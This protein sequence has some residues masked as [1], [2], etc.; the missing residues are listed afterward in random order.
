MIRR[1]CVPV[2]YILATIA[3]AACG[4]GGGGGGGSGGGTTSPPPTGNTI[5]YGSSNYQYT[6]GIEAQTL[7][8]SN[9]S[10]IKTWS[11]S[12]ALPAGLTFDTSTGA[13]SGTPTATSP[14]TAYA[15]TGVS[16]GGQVQLSLAIGVTSN[17]LLNLGDVDSLQFIQFDAAHAVTQDSSGHWILWNY[18]TTAQIANGVSLVSY[19][20]PHTHDTIETIPAPV[21]LAGPTAVIQTAN[22]LEVRSS[23]TGEV[24]AEIAVHL[25]WW[26]LAADGSYVCAGNGTSLTCWSPSG[27]QLFSEAGNYFNAMVFAAPSQLLVGLGGAGPQVIET[28]STATW[29]SSVGPAFQG[30]FSSWFV[31]GSHFLATIPEGTQ[32]GTTIAAFNTLYVYSPASV[33][34]DAATMP[35][36]Q[37]LTGQGNWFWTTAPS[38]LTLY[39]I[40]NNTTSCIPIPCTTPTPTATYNLS[41]LTPIGTFIASITGSALTVIDLTGATPV[42]STYTLP[43]ANPS[44]FAAIAPSQFM[45]GTG[46]GVIIDGST[47]NSPRVFDYGAVTNLVGGTARAVFTTASGST[48]SY[49]TTTDAFEPTLNL[50]ADVQL[51]LSANGG[52]L[53]GLDGSGNVNVYSMPSGPL[54]N[55][56]PNNGGGPASII[57]SAAGTILGE[58]LNN[59]TDATIPV[60]GGAPTLYPNAGAMLLFSPD[61]TLVAVSDT[62]YPPSYGTMYGGSP[63]TSIYKNGT[64]LT[65]VSGWALQWLSTSS[66][67]VANYVCCTG[68]VGGGA[69]I[70]TGNQA[71]TPTGTP[72][73]TP[74]PAPITWASADPSSNSAVAGPIAVLVSGNLVIAQPF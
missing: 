64:L 26:N 14:T 62:A 49:N 12:P 30:A 24:L 59:G 74:P 34:E 42:E 31:D 5:S 40:G 3:I 18:V 54:I 16:S 60:T 35:S 36:L 66:F 43:V 61:G 51:A 1:I 68:G 27:Q 67:L 41:P 19:V 23:A 48:F 56:F 50:A 58:M 57:L 17:I 13:I 7:T 20:P 21:A 46:E 45:V 28:V 38:P 9:A 63:T 39:A 52:V 11:I 25:Q 4:G 44:A 15:I 8:P 2:A 55:S 37:G 69:A 47:P 33:L 10:S 70:F 32:I 65:T 71:Y 6:V 72:L 53:A 22:G 29:T 73:P